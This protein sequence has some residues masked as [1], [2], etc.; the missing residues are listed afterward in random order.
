MC[1]LFSVAYLILERRASICTITFALCALPHSPATQ[2]PSN[3]ELLYV[4]SYP[5]AL[6]FPCVVLDNSWRD[7]RPDLSGNPQWGPL[8]K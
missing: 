3:H 2:Q 7:G 5:V 8:G 6:R 1:Y 4:L